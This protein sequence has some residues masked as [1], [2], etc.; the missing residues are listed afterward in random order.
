MAGLGRRPGS[1]TTSSTEKQLD[2]VWLLGAGSFSIGIVAVICYGATFGL[3]TASAGVLVA[4]SAAAV[5]VVVGFLFGIPGATR[6]AAD[7]LPS[8]TESQQSASSVNTNLMEISD[9]LTKIIVGV[10]LVELGKLSVRFGQLDGVLGTVL[11]G[12]PLG[13]VVGA[14]ELIYFSAIGFVFGYIITRTYISTT[15]KLF[16][17]IEPNSV[18]A[19]LVDLVSS[20]GRHVGA[21]RISLAAPRAAAISASDLTPEDNQEPV[22]PVSDFDTTVSDV[23]SL[24][25]RLN[26]LLVELIFPL[27]PV[28]RTMRD[29]IRVLV[30]RGVLD[31][32]SAKALNGLADAADKVLSGATVP[33]KDAQA[34]LNSGGTVLAELSTLRA[35]A[36][37]LAEEFVLGRL[38]RE[39]IRRTWTIVRKAKVE[40][41]NGPAS[42]DALIL[43]P[44][45]RSEV[46]VEV[47]PRLHSSA[48]DHIEALHRWLNTVRRRRIRILLVLLGDGLDAEDMARLT[49]QG[50]TVLLWDYDSG[51]LPD[52][53]EH[54]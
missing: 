51:S 24:M 14:S 13:V 47:R 22:L 32:S 8:I 35:F 12:K 33:H 27:P 29:M 52:R 5:G 31:D 19:P 28:N 26:E 49:D 11:G 20:L 36:P 9:W 1:G 40:T 50:V 6:R 48:R 42:V 53:V 16:D 43:L 25:A 2:S 39:A 44:A 37:A 15:F 54:S 10:G 46:V 3:P 45:R 38:Q 4:F 7:G 18:S 21:T 17:S 30:G 23:S 41:E 34:V